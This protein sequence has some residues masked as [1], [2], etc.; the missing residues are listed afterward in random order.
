MGN[1]ITRATPWRHPSFDG[2]KPIHIR[3][4]DDVDNEALRGIELEYGEAVVGGE[5]RE[6]GTT[7]VFVQE[8]DYLFVRFGTLLDGRHVNLR[9]DALPELLEAARA[10][11]LDG[12]GVSDTHSIDPSTGV[13]Y[14]ET[15]ETRRW[16]SVVPVPGAGIPCSKQVARNYAAG[17]S[18]AFALI[19]HAELGK[20]GV[21]GKEWLALG[22]PPELSLD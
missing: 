3:V 5:R 9:A 17:I 4:P 22:K 2:I 6:V 20:I 11:V 8:A 16:G 1:R 13:A 18:G 15:G 21:T 10:Q 7:G 19:E 14:T 12:F